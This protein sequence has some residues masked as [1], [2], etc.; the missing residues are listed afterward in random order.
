MTATTG[1]AGREAGGNASGP[2]SE[3]A[4]R[5]AGLD[6]PAA[7]TGAAADAE[8]D[9]FVV[10]AVL[11][12]APVFTLVCCRPGDLDL[13]GEHFPAQEI[14]MLRRDVLSE[15]AQAEVRALFTMVERDGRRDGVIVG[16]TDGDGGWA[17]WGLGFFAP[18]PGPVPT[19]P[20]AGDEGQ[21]GPLGAG[22]S[23]QEHCPDR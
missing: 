23:S 13:L 7:P 10:A 18:A 4:G 14:R 9:T 11:P 21:G 6:G 12:R 20:P 8:A 22:A 1:Q 5:D 17:S 19:L 3:R 2:V 16:T 15:D